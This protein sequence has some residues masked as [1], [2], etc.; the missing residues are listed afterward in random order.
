MSGP[1]GRGGISLSGLPETQTLT[2]MPVDPAALRFIRP[3]RPGHTAFD[4]GTITGGHFLSPGTGIV[5]W[6]ELNTGQGLPGTNYRIWVN[7]T[8]T[9]IFAMYHFEI[10]GSVP[11]QTQRDNIL[12]AVGDR[13]TAGQHIG[14]LISKGHNA[15]V[16]FDVFGVGGVETDRCPLE[17]FS[18][19]VATALENLYDSGS[20]EDRSS[21]PDLC[22]ASE[23]LGS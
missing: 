13:V 21:L 4:I 14:N 18:P 22:N 12:V 15:H 3:S 9:G 20:L 7:F 2:A 1:V 17:F 10:D 19:E 11:D 16:H 6:V 23:T 8:S 5:T